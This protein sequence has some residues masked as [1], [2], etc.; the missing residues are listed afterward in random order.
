LKDEV[1]ATV[2]KVS[3]ASSS[4]RDPLPVREDLVEK[5]KAAALDVS[6]CAIS[7]LL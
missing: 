5:V 7:L 2:D 1:S 3:G 6:V 4:K